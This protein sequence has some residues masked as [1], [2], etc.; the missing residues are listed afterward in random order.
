MASLL[1][2]K[3]GSEAIFRVE[4]AWDFVIVDVFVNAFCLVGHG[5]QY[6]VIIVARLLGIGIAI[7]P[8]IFHVFELV[9]VA[10]FV[11]AF[12]GTADAVGVVVPVRVPL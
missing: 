10:D 5:E 4:F 7:V 9:L 2:I 11:A 6:D 3:E 12:C 8:M 1:M